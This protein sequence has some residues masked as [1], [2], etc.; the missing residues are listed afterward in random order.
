MTNKLAIVI[1]LHSMRVQLTVTNIQESLML[2]STCV[3]QVLFDT[4][5]FITFFLFTLQF[6]CD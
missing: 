4:I 5:K 6:Y 3:S 2:F 1:W